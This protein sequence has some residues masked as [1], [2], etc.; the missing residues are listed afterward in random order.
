MIAVKKVVDL[1][2]TLNLTGCQENLNEI[3]DE[4]EQTHISYANFLKNLLESEITF[5]IEKKITRNMSAA[6]FPLLKKMEDF[7][8][9]RVKGVTKTE[10][11]LLTDFRWIDNHKNLLFFGPPGLGKTHLAI[12]IGYKA[13][14]K[15]YTVCFEKITN[16]I[17]LLKSQE[18]QRSS[19][20]RIRRIL[21]SDVIIID[22]I[23]YTPIDRK[24]ANLFFNLISELYE[25]RSV[26]ITSNKSFNNW[27][28]MLDDSILTTALLDRLLHHAKIFTLDGDS[29]RI[30]N[31]NKEV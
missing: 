6:H 13:I 5:R 12:A 21:K 31:K 9:G 17:R 25:K 30:N 24:E 7:K 29:Y 14:E 8:F 18:I 22:E 20:F 23:G 1:L 19:A 2:R 11:A 16:L 28:E 3:L 27:A 10:I 26:I 15:G 4:S